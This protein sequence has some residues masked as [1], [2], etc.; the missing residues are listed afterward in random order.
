MLLAEAEQFDG[1]GE[2]VRQHGAIQIDHAAGSLCFIDDKTAADGIVGVAMQLTVIAFDD[3]GHGVGVERQ[4]FVDQA[5]VPGPDER[6]RQTTVE[7][8]RV[9]FAQGFDADADLRRIDR[10]R[11][12]AHQA[13][14]HRV[15]A[16]VTDAG[17]RQR[18]IKL[19]FDAPYLFQKTLLTQTLHEQRRGAHR[20]HG[21]RTGR[22]DADFEQV[23]NT[24]SHYCRTPGCAN[25]RRKS[26]Q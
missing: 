10:V 11:P 5:H 24:D 4:V 26:A 8:Q 17:G 13:H 22:A 16:A 6:D 9:G 18:T 14:D 25:S 19:N 3:Q 2:I 23:E 12:L 7:Q 1:A 21:V 20:P 15:V